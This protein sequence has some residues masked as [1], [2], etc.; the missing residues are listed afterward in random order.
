MQD[1]IKEVVKNEEDANRI[2]Q[3]ARSK[4]A[5]LL[6]AADAE[7]GEKIRALKQEEREK[8]ARMAEE[9]EKA[10]ADRVKAAQDEARKDFEERENDNS[11]LVQKLVD[12]AVARVCGT[13]FDGGSR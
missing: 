5:G 6:G 13:V 7:A 11:P 10:A 8:T 3:E 12:Q 4:A 1:L 2:V 9:A